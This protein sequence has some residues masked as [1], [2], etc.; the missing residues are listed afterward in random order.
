MS[1]YTLE[2]KVSIGNKYLVPKQIKEHGLTTKDIK[3]GKPVLKKL[4]SGYT[5]ESGIRGLDKTIAKVI[6]NRAK[7]IALEETF[8]TTFETKHVE[9]VLGP[10][11]ISM[12]AYENNDV[13]GVV[14][15]LAWTQMGGDILFIPAGVSHEVK[16]HN[17]NPFS[18]YKGSTS[19]VRSVT[20]LGD[21]M[22]SVEDLQSQG[23]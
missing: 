15:G 1:G 20:E 10:E 19:G 4:I 16:V 8:E 14:T 6:R 12:N 23:R 22:G 18:A 3:I 5:R 11:K 7:S 21:G 13:P 2:E 17:S 9:S